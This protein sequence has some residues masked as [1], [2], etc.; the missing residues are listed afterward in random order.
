M[1]E[2][3]DERTLREAHA[4]EADDRVAGRPEMTDL[5]RRLRHHQSTWRESKGHPIGTQPIAPHPGQES[6]PLGSRLPLAYARETGANF[7]TKGALAAARSRMAFVEPNQSVDHQRLW[8][9]LLWSPSMAINLFGDLAADLA[10]ADRAV[11]AWWPD[12][13]GTVSAVRFTH[14][15]GWLD[16]AY[17]RSLR[18]FDALFELDL[19]DGTKAALAVDVKYH[20]WL[21][22]ETPKPE[23]L[24]RY[25]EVARRSKA[26]RR[27]AVASL[28]GRGGLAV[29]WLEHLLLL[30]M[31]QHASGRWTWG[32][33]VIV[34]P[35][36][37]S[38]FAE[39]TG[40]YRGL[41]A[42]DSTFGTI[43]LE[44]L[45]DGDAGARRPS[46]TRALRERY[47][48]R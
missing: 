9:D 44:E 45:L 4:W 26:F 23:N 25:R 29:M 40:R 24:A 31:L 36:G 22:P 38:D 18:E 47:L 21:K 19:R 20:E 11:H 6:R 8:A 30:S 17:L 33:Y 43:T 10:V 37:N 42:D 39:A 5:R 48:P 14:S 12:A 16:P 13:P 15:P 7:V 27:R 34:H 2:P 1:Q 3:L 46:T 41:L 28:E 35:E 32:R